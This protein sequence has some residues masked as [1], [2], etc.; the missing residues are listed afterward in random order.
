MTYY[1]IISH[2]DYEWK[3]SKLAFAA[4]LLVLEKEGDAS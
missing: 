3:G 2:D 1:Y 4:I